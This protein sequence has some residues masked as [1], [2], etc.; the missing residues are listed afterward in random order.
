M[1]CRCGVEVLTH[2]NQAARPSGMLVVVADGT[3]LER[4]LEQGAISEQISVTITR[5]DK[6]VTITLGVAPES[7]DRLDRALAQFEDFCTVSQSVRTGI[8]FTVTVV[9]PDGRVVK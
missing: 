3:W 4:C 1:V 6:K 5:Q 2:V 7:L 9:S 8:P